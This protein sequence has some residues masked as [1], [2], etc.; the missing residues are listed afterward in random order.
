MVL[1]LGRLLDALGNRQYKFVSEKALS[2]LT[3]RPDHI[4]VHSNDCFVELH[5]ALVLF[6]DKII[7][8]GEDETLESQYVKQG[9]HQVIKYAIARAAGVLKNV[10]PDEESDW[11]AYAVFTNGQSVRIFRA[12]ISRILARSPLY[13]QLR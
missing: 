7:D 11:T 12:S 1:L 6:E 9:S 2:P 4:L 8:E 3:V 10:Y 5:S 13:L